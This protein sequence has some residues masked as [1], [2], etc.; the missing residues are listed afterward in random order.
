MDAAHWTHFQ[1]ASCKTEFWVQAVDAC[2]QQESS[3]R[4]SGSPV[5][6]PHSRHQADHVLYL[7]AHMPMTWAQ[8]AA[9]STSAL[10]ALAMFYSSWAL[11]QPQCT[12]SSKHGPQSPILA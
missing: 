4:C 7:A 2:Q 8:S 11:P 3:A 9:A 12:T 5:C 10:L 6:G 1:Q